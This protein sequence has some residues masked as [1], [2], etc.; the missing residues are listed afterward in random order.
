MN[1]SAEPPTVGPSDRAQRALGAVAF[2]ELT[3]GALSLSGD[4]AGVLESVKAASDIYAPVGGMVVA[5]AAVA[6]L[7]MVA[8]SLVEFVSG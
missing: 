7:V 3:Q 5:I 2:V 8:F 1:S 6:S 4:G